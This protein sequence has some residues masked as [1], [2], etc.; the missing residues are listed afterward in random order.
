MYEFERNRALLTMEL[1]SG[2]DVS[3]PEFE[4]DLNIDRDIN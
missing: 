3:I 1:I 2:V 4:P